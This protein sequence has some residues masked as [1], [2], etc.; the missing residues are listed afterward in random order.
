MSSTFNLS[1]LLTLC[2]VL[3][4]VLGHAQFSDFNYSRTMGVLG[5]QQKGW[6]QLELPKDISSKTKAN[7]SDIR[8]LGLTETGDSL[9]VPYLQLQSF[10]TNKIKSKTRPPAFE[11]INQSRRKEGFYYTFKLLDGKE[12]T[13]FKLNFK[14]LNF[15]WLV[16]LEGS[17]NQQKWFTLLEDYR[18]LGINNSITNYEFTTL[19]FPKSD[20]KYFRVLM[21]DKTDD[22]LVSAQIETE[23]KRIKQKY[24]VLNISPQNIIENKAK[25]QTE[26]YLSMPYLLTTDELGIEVKNDWDFYRRISIHSLPESFKTKDRNQD[27]YPSFKNTILNSWDN[28][29]IYLSRNRKIQHLKIIIYNEDN[30]P[31]DVEKISVKSPVYSLAFRLPEKAD[32]ILFYGNDKATMPNYDLTHFKDKIP[33]NLEN[34]VLGNEINLASLKDSLPKPKKIPN[35]YWLW[36]L[37]GFTIL[38]LGGFSIKML[39]SVD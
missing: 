13:T 10:H 28:N 15:D 14:N 17:H 26:I 18:I 21:K 27:Q 24:H 39:R 4:T 25:K 31:L 6:H 1:P 9:E 22:S 37:L 34:V 33:D 2:F 30:M 11:I 16:N 32:C 36:L 19:K 38:L 35:K 5:T 23:L 7:F 12:I 8:I 3:Y 20:Y 29:L